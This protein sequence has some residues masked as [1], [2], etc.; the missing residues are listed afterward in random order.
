MNQSLY[1]VVEKFSNEG[2]SNLKLDYEITRMDNDILSV[3]YKGTVDME[4]IGN[5]KI[6]DSINLDTAKTGQQITV[7]NY[8]KQDEKS[9][10]E[11]VLESSAKAAGIDKI[12]AEGMKM[13]FKDDEVIFYYTPLDDSAE[14]KAYIPVKES[15]LKGIAVEEFEQVYFS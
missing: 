1:S 10:F 14:Y 15:D 6:V 5:I 4:G 9:K 12:E 3:L 11:S 7:D 13:Y 8:I 2:Y